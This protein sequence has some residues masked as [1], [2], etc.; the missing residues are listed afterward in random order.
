[1]FSGGR[2]SLLCIPN[3]RGMRHWSCSSRVLGSE[4]VSM[5]YSSLF[6]IFWHLEAVHCLSLI[7]G[8]WKA[9]FSESSRKFCRFYSRNLFVN[10]LG[11]SRS[12]ISSR[13]SCSP[14]FLL[15]LIHVLTWC[16]GSLA[17]SSRSRVCV[18][19]FELAT[20]VQLAMG[21]TAHLIGQ[22]IEGWW[23]V[24]SEFLSQDGWH[25]YSRH[26]IMG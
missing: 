1:M 20:I 22:F 5:T 13:Q 7:F 4:S 12:R 17:P 18:L 2:C 8:H 16:G 24:I 25:C 9:G 10:R 21:K 19:M 26:Q 14:S 3:S 15:Q 6:V 11:C 23:L